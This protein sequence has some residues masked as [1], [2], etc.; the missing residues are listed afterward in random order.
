M[1]P[2]FS[3]FI[4]L[5]AYTHLFGQLDSARWYFTLAD[6]D[7]KLNVDNQLIISVDLP[8]GW[9]LYS[10]DFKPESLGPA[11][12]SFQ[13]EAVTNYLALDDLRPIRPHAGS[14]P[15]FD[16]HY[17][18]FVSKAEFRQCIRLVRTKTH[19]KGVVKGQFFHL[20]S[21]EAQPFEKTFDYTIQLSSNP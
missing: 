10:T 3:L 8:D 18:Y 9:G 21:G 2:L 12:T 15:A 17:T 20:Q 14:E 7:P 4:V 1:K 6:A 19:I 16:F 5:S 13:F 11:P